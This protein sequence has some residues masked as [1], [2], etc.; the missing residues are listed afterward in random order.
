MRHID[1]V[2]N[3]ERPA[4]DNSGVPPFSVTPVD[5]Y[6][7]SGLSPDAVIVHD[8]GIIHFANAAFAALLG[9]P[10]V[11]GIVGKRLVD[12][13]SPECHAVLLGAVSHSVSQKPHPICRL[14][15][16]DGQDVFVEVVCAPVPDAQAPVVF[17]H[18]RDVTAQRLAEEALERERRQ[19][20]AV[21]D[22]LDEVIYV[23]DPDTYEVLYANQ[24]VRLRFGD[25]IGQKCFKSLQ[26]LD[27]PCTFCTNRHIFGA[28]CGKP[29]TWE[30]RNR[31]DGRWYH[32]IDR[33]IEWPGRQMVRHEVA[34]DITDRKM[35]ES[36]LQQTE[37][38]LRSFLR[39]LP[40]PVFVK[41]AKN[42][43]FTMWNRAREEL[44]G[45]SEEQAL[46]KT[47][48]DIFME[49]QADSFRADDVKTLDSR[50]I[51][52]IPEEAVSTQHR[53][54][55]IFHSR[56]IPIFDSEGQPEYLL[57]V[58]EDITE[59]KHAERAL[60][61]SEEKYHRLFEVFPDPI[62]LME[63]SGGLL[64]CNSAACKL[65][66]YTQEEML[67]LNAADIA[68]GF[69]D[70]ASGLLEQEWVRCGR[71]FV[72]SQGRKKNGDV[73]PTEL[74]AMPV[75]MGARRLALVHVRD[76]TSRKH[77][78]QQRQKLEE[79]I[80]QTQKLESMGVLAGGIAHDFNNLLTAILGYADLTSTE[81]SPVSSAF[82]NVE[83][84]SKTARR[85]A[86]LTRQML[87]YSGRGRFIIRPICLSRLVQDMAPLLE[88]S[89]SKKCVLKIRGPETMPL[90]QG[91]E[92]QVRQVL[93]NFVINASEAIAD[94]SGVITI[95]T[96]VMDCDRG[97]LAKTYL[98]QDLPAGHYAYLEVTD[99]GCGMTH[100]VLAKIF[101][102]FFTTKFTGRGL[103]L[104]A[105]LGIVRGHKGA[106]NVY[107]EQGKGSS[108]KVL[109]PVI[110]MHDLEAPGAVQSNESWRGSGTILVVDDEEIVRN[111]AKKMLQGAGFNVLTASNGREGI[112]VFSAHADEIR[113]IILDMTMP[114]LG[115]EEAFTELKR[116]R[117]DARIVLASGYNEQEVT[118][119]FAGKGLAGFI[120]KPFVSAELLRV[121][122]DALE[123]KH[124]VT[125]AERRA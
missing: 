24:A 63:V 34:I 52:E 99:S 8:G 106:I 79:Q 85:A 21:F 13:V 122:K 104:A 100:D 86:E 6:E 15:R 117:A 50:D 92:A 10:N 31:L 114:H 39:D 96:G 26:G 61:E 80:L 116:V 95:R 56:R 112:D 110:G 11:Q 121:I 119:R 18:F 38:L 120:Q 90:I 87:A 58:S 7:L 67:N 94:R 42:F 113:L 44:L 5:Q 91:D 72:E 64:E 103:G 62:F 57:G 82:D 75:T 40:V 71:Y 43:R 23:S 47:D 17:V 36:R 98:D 81:L 46:G 115:G 93:M 25:V 66:D 70:A 109:L 69:P 22:N 53:G 30:L 48:Y 19:L 77:A 51:L 84:I 83:Q 9:I 102:P 20:I 124:G 97:Y 49:E 101:D 16:L 68:P 55:R 3:A 76:I 88:V 29:F 45:M 59:R 65:Y 41:D 27:A 32:C 14:V 37:E 33:A 107:T 105:V 54:L 118:E 28:N 74:T 1:D 89:I 108:F 111:L 78:E 73:F 12:Y 2:S 125:V 123:R 60:R 4:P 35:A